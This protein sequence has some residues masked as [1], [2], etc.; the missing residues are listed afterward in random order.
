MQSLLRRPFTV[1][2]FANWFDPICL[3]PVA[4]SRYASDSSLSSLSSV[5]WASILWTHGGD[6]C[7]MDGQVFCCG[8]TEDRHHGLPCGALSDGRL[9]YAGAGMHAGIGCEA[10][11]RSDDVDRGNLPELRERVSRAGFAAGCSS[12]GQRDG[13]VSSAAAA[14]VPVEPYYKSM[15]VAGFS[16]LCA[17]LRG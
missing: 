17:G 2:A 8:A 11:V 13:E 12:A 5:D 4:A 14:G 9:L 3:S 7:I 15:R 6:T 1:S 16:R 10:R